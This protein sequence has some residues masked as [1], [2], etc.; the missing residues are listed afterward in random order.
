MELPVITIIIANHNYGRWLAG[1]VKSALNQTYPKNKTNIIVVDDGSTDDSWN[2]LHQNFYKGIPHNKSVQNGMDV[3]DGVVNGI[4]LISIK[5]PEARGPSYAR[6]I[7]IDAMI[8]G[9]FAFA[10]LDADDEYYPNKLELLVLKMLEAPDTIGVTYGDYDILNT[11]TGLVL[12]EYKQP[13]DKLVLNREC[14][15]HSGALINSKALKATAET[16]GYYDVNMRTCEDF[17]LWMRI[18]DKFMIVH[19]P[20]SLSLV[21]VT[22]YNST[23]TVRQEIWQKNWK[24]VSDKAYTRAHG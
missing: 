2:V 21:R 3:K 5:S 22:P 23:N 13:F 19:V 10:V 24:R 15:V 6:N 20:E 16:T 8:E 7:A 18:S 17:D 1:S 4:R 12:R 9:S 14:I 11:D